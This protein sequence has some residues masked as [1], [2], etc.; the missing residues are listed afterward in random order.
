[1]TCAL[2]LCRSRTRSLRMW[3]W[4]T[5][6]RMTSCEW[7]HLPITIPHYSTAISGRAYLGD[8]RPCSRRS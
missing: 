5:T 3:C 2:V 4:S 1:M 6:R 8:G 7:Q